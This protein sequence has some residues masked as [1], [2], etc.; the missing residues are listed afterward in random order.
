ML[1][2]YFEAGPRLGDPTLWT[3]KGHK[4]IVDST[5]L[6]KNENLVQVAYP[7]SKAW[8]M[9][10]LSDLLRGWGPQLISWTKTNNGK[11]YGHCSALIGTDD[12]TTQVIIHDPENAPNTRMTLSAFN[13][14]FMWNIL[15]SMLRKNVLKHTP[16]LAPAKQP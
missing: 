8:T 10:A 11:T 12:S 15:D 4:P 6:Q 9:D 5:N 14:A 1:G 7:P 3:P 16:K 2:Y 13:G